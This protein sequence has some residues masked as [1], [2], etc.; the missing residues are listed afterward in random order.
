MSLYNFNGNNANVF[1]VNSS[2][3]LNNNNVNNTNGV[4]PIFF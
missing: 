2:G 4:R 3:N 1:R